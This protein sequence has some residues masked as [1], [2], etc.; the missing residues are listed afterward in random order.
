MGTLRNHAA[1]GLGR[2]RSDTLASVGVGLRFQRGVFN[3]SADYGRLVN[4]SRIPT[5]VNSASPQE[6][7][8]RFYVSVGVQF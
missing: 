8:E 6:G 5:S 1:N 4:G 3:A 2:P 7:D